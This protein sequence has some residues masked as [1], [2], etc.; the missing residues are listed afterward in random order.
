MHAIEGTEVSRATLFPALKERDRLCSGVRVADDDNG[1]EV[2]IG[3][4]DPIQGGV[5]KEDVTTVILANQKLKSF[6]KVH[7]LPFEDTFQYNFEH[8]F[9][10]NIKPHFDKKQEGS[11]EKGFEFAFDG[12]RFRVVDAVFKDEKESGPGV[13]TRNTE[14]FYEGPLN[15]RTVLK[16]LHV[17]PL[18]EDVTE[19]LFM[20][21]H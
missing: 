17:L 14:M 7:V 5:F 2:L 9:Q 8:L 6:A 13:V 20:Y 21:L 3:K 4:C 10:K 18:T 19:F 16:S 1:V 12:I 15:E 11:F